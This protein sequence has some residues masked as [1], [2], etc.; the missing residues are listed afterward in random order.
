MT[1]IKPGDVVVIKATVEA[2]RATRWDEYYE[3]VI[4][5]YGVGS[6]ISAREVRFTLDKTMLSHNRAEA[7]AQEEK[8]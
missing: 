7:P 6:D 8:P 5:G 3:L 2:V 1:R 4:E